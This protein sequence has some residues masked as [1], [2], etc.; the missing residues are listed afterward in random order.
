MNIYVEEEKCVN[1]HKRY[2]LIEFESR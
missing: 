2:E 1:G